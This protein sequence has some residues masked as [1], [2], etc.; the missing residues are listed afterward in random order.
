MSRAGVADFDARISRLV[1]AGAAI[2]ILLIAEVFRGRSDG[3]IG[4]EFVRGEMT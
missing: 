1:Y 3:A 4:Q 2:V